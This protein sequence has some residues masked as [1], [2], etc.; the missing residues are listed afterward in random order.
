MHNMISELSVS[1]FRLYMHVL[2]CPFLV[3]I[4][5]SNKAFKSL[6]KIWMPSTNTQNYFDFADCLASEKNEMS[7]QKYRNKEIGFVSCGST[8][9]HIVVAFE[10]L[11]FMMVVLV[12]AVRTIFHALPMPTRFLQTLFKRRIALTFLSSSLIYRSFFIRTHATVG[13]FTRKTTRIYTI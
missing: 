3:K 7:I 1:Y 8:F 6:V 13:T 9:D 5:S 4:H 2:F 10:A 12:S 11:A